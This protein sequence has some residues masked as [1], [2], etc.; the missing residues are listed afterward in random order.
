M[1]TKK[2]ETRRLI[3]SDRESDFE[4]D[5]KIDNGKLSIYFGNCKYPELKQVILDL[6]CGKIGGGK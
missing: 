6:C 1:K 3:I 4:C 5:V 2:E